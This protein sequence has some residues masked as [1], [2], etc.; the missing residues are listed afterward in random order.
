MLYSVTGRFGN[1]FTFRVNPVDAETPHEAIEQIYESKE[2][3]DYAANNETSVVLITAKAFSG[4]KSRI[5]ISDEPAKERQ[6]GKKKK[7]TPAPATTPA[8]SGARK[9]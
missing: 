2:I 5:R 7:G 6:G 9:R 3:K 8:P 1:N 4:K